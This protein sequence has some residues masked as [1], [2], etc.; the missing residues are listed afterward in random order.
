MCFVSSL[1]TTSFQYNLHSEVRLGWI[2]V[3]IADNAR[4]CSAPPYSSCL[5]STGSNPVSLCMSIL[6]VERAGN[7]LGFTCR[8]SGPGPG[9]AAGTACP[10]S[11]PRTTT[12]C[13]SVLCAW[14]VQPSGQEG[15]PRFRYPFEFFYC[16]LK[17][18][19]YNCTLVCS[20][21]IR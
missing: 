9:T 10:R 5:A 17:Y 20:V 4:G 16:L 8:T 11:S 13:S 15:V 12:P 21:N 14:D 19:K 1:P 6:E 3:C 2:L 18:C 7:W